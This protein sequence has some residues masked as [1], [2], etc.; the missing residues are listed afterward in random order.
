MSST[1]SIGLIGAGTLGKSLALGL[2]AAGYRVTA[3]ANRTYASAVTL[4][5]MIP[6]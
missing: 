6:G 2:A 4:A 1:L 3:V 5:E